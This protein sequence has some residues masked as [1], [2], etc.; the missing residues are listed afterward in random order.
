LA[1]NLLKYLFQEQCQKRLNDKPELGKTTEKKYPKMDSIMPKLHNLAGFPPI[2][3]K[4]T[5]NKVTTKP[6]SFILRLPTHYLD[7]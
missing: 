4:S 6:V 1:K 5:V 2:E 3:T 7:T